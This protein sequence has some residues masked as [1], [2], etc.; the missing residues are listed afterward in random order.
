M[1]LQFGL[2]GRGPW[3]RNIE[4]T[5]LSFPDV[6]VRPIERHAAVAPNLDAVL[7]VTSSASHAHVAL[8]YIRAGLPT[9]IEKPMATSVADAEALRTAAERSGGPIFIGHLFLHHPAFQK[10]LEI[11]PTL[12]RVRYLLNE[13]ANNSPRSD[14]SVLWDW[15]PHDLSMA[16]AIFGT[17]AS[18]AEAWPLSGSPR[19][20]AALSKFT[21]EGS[22]VV[23][24]TS[25]LSSYRRKRLTVVCE[26]GTLV[27]DDRA[28]RKLVLH[29]T[30]ANVSFPAFEAR[31][32]L[33][34]ELEKFTQAVRSRKSDPL[35]LA[36]GV[37]VVRMI[38]AAERSL[39]N[40]GRPVE[41]E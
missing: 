28:E 16:R 7:V 24:T 18:T 41:I 29:D 32:P 20:Q 4:R 10:L 5:L 22:S 14:S 6:S 34:Q 26:A 40:G 12:G 31:L 35:E 36:A 8:P 15:L 21:F 9:F 25:W 2:I 1:A 19:P 39:E 33:T 30:K 3:G 38:A 37:S 27:F 11:L 17:D 23:C 13:S